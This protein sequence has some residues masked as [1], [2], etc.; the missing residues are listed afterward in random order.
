MNQER[1]IPRK[2]STSGGLLLLL[3]VLTAVL[4]RF[5]QLGEWPPGLYRDEAYNGLDALNVLDGR[6]ALFFPANNGREPAYIYLSALTIGLFGPSVWALR[7]GAALVGSLTTIPVFLLG[8][9][10]FG[11]RVGL[12]AAWLWAITLWPVHLSRIG[13]RAVLLVPCLALVFWLG[14]QAYRQEQRRWWLLAG[15]V[16][17]LA[18]YTYLAVRLTPLVLLGLGLYLL[19]TR[20]EQA[21]RLVWGALWFGL[22]TAAS[23]TPLLLLYLQQP[24]LLLGRTGQ[25]SILNEAVHHGN[26]WATLWRH[27]GLGLGMFV[28]QGDT[29]LRHNPAGRPVFDWLM[30]LPFLL[31]VGWCLWAAWRQQAAAL[32]VLLWTAVMLLPTIL[33]DDTPHFLRAV[34]VLPAALYFPALGLDKFIEFYRRNFCRGEDKERREEKIAT[35]YPPLTAYYLIFTVLIL[36]SLMLTIRDYSRYA[37]ETDTSYLFEAAA[38]ALAESV[39][40]AGE[41]TA[42]FVDERFWQGWPSLRF[43]TT[44]PLQT[45]RPEVGLTAVPAPPLA[46]YAWPYGPLD[47]LPP[48]LRP[49]L[50]VAVE[51]GPLA[52]GDL[53]PE[54]Y[55]LYTRYTIE[56]AP[57]AWPLAINFDQTLWLRQA[58]ATIPADD[59]IVVALVWE[60]ETAVTR[61]LVAF[62][63]LIG[64]DG[65]VTQ[66]DAPPGQGHWSSDWWQPGLVLHEQRSLH[67]PHPFDPAQ[68]QIHVGLYDA[69]TDERLLRQDEPDDFYVIPIAAGTYR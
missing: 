14:T 45:F 19:L 69:G 42:V 12:L 52:R 39:N 55:A 47:F 65:L 31:G 49:P 8:R 63:H 53:E 10:W 5:Y 46:V 58:T 37:Q 62:V 20:R 68:H 18:F 44:R 17:G 7:L 67:L 15:L 40:G 23:L 16:Y 26:L 50:L 24:E 38:R 25:V 13:L 6:H 21:G 29:I 35:R 32:T 33:A 41:E 57:T 9:R 1:M 54:A 66:L 48:A 60:G 3:A 56:T 27:L 36:A 2:L 61:P 51:S 64:P 30:A 43:L 11:L 22:G 34:G 59:V 4:L 28:W